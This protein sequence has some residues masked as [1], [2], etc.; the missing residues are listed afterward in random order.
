MGSTMKIVFVLL[1][2]MTTLRPETM[3]DLAQLE[4]MAVRFS[5]AELR[6]DLSPLSKGDREALV[7]LIRAS[8]LIDDIFLQQ[9]W[10]GNQALY[11]KLKR[12]TTP[13]GRRVCATS[14]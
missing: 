12:D 4:K 7:K 11:A 13:L 14:G 5:R 3:P 6:A 10:S 9:L 2:T 8:Q 1:F